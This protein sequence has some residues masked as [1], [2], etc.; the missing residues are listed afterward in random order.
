MNYHLL[1]VISY[2]TFKITFDIL[3]CLFVCLFVLVCIDFYSY[4]KAQ[5]FYRGKAG[6]KWNVNKD[7]H[8]HIF[9]YSWTNNWSGMPFLKHL[10]VFPQLA[11]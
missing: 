5:I 10:V 9:M 1:G 11:E 3:N 4:Y 7:I 6:N 2:I 8:Q